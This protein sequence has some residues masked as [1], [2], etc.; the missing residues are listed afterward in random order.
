MSING[1]VAPYLELWHDPVF[2]YFLIACGILSLICWLA[3][4]ITDNY[5]QVD[6]LWSI[7]P[8][9][10]AWFFVYFGYQTNAE[11]C[12]RSS[13]MA[14][15]VTLW[16]ARLTYNFWRKDGYNLKTE[17]YRWIYVRKMFFYPQYKIP[18]HIFN[19][20]FT[21]VLQ[22]LLLMFLV[23]PV[24]FVQTD[25]NVQSDL[26]SFDYLNVVLFLSFLLIETI[27]DQQQW[28]YQ[29]KKYDWIDNKESKKT[30][31]SQNEIEDFK[32]GFLIKGLFKYSRHPNFWAEQSIWWIVYSFT[33]SSQ[34]DFLKTNLSIGTLVNYSC[35]ATVFL[36]SLFQGSTILTEWITTK[37][38]PEY[39]NYSDRVSRFFP[40]FTTYQPGKTK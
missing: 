16:G 12:T 15:L 33:L 18:Y 34:M 14:A 11:R 32:R 37:K 40:W 10:Y 26:N 39:K 21:A 20:V 13:I 31:Y 38:Y 25:K 35:F 6:R 23:V 1:I 7:I 28:V 30:K 2:R 29:T 27:A 4:I 5:S 24:W 17:D 22:N 8:A 36:T 9:V 19:F 3:T